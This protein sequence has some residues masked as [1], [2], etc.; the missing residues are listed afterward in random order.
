MSP[1]LYVI[2]GPNGAG[3]TTFAKQFLPNYAVAFLLP[4]FVFRIRNKVISIDRKM[5]VII[6]LLAGGSG[7]TDTGGILKKIGIRTYKDCPHCGTKNR[8]DDYTW[9]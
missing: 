7:N 8:S 5:D 3:K 4:F 2:A 9:L 6:E 1:N